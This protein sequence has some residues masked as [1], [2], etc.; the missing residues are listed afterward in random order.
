MGEDCLWSEDFDGNWSTTCKE[1]FCFID[2]GPQEN[3]M[4]YCCYC[5]LVLRSARYRAEEEADDAK[6]RAR[7]N[8]TTN[9]TA[10]GI[11]D[12]HTN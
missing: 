6:E 12:D 5:G 10:Q 7:E 2:G 8:G 11:D 3:N 1:M 9:R 4:S